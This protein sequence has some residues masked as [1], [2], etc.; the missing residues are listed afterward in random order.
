M[1]KLS[2]AK[3]DEY[4]DK[5]RLNLVLHGAPAKFLMELRAKGF[6]RTYAHGINEGI[7][8][9]YDSIVQKELRIAHFHTLQETRLDGEE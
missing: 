7:R 9:L 4:S 3:D 5:I 8:L 2:K 1:R 6:I